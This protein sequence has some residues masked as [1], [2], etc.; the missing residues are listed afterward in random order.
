MT[1]P[2][3]RAMLAATA[4]AHGFAVVTRNVKDYQAIDGLKIINPWVYDNH[5]LTAR[6][7]NRA[8]APFP[9]PTAHTPRQ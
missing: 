3:S 2:A 8:N 6:A 4:M 1:I 9:P 5:R 7:T